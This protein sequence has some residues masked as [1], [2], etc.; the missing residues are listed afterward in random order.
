MY[1]LNI[2]IIIKFEFIFLKN[3]GVPK[4]YIGVPECS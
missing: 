4:I 2:Y 1:F 3:I